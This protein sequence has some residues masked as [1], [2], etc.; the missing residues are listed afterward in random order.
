MPPFYQQMSHGNKVSSQVTLHLP[1]LTGAQSTQ[2]HP[3]QSC[4]HLQA[5]QSTYEV[6]MTTQKQLLDLESRD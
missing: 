5:G 3:T 1:T 4:P 6:L 2:G